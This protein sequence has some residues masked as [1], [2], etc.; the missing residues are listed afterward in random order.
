MM[1]VIAGTS[2]A[3]GLLATSASAEFKYK[4]DG[5]NT[6]VEFVGTKPQGK[7]TGGFKKTKG[8]GYRAASDEFKYKL[9]GKNT[10]V[11]FVGTKPQGKHTGGF[12]KLKGHVSGA[13]SDV[14]TGK[15]EVEIDVK[16][17]YSDDKKLTG[18]LLS[19]DFFDVKSH[20]T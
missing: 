11:E 18:H 8:P 5:K 6:E 10:E 12:K 7:H 9:D 1:R 20:P 2:V 14:T 3:A 13:G 17:L 4:L 16:S 19:A 15:V